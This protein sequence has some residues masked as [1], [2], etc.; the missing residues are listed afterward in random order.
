M[1]VSENGLIDGLELY[2]AALVA[3]EYA[4]NKATRQQVSRV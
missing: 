2:S 4:E 1:L 3:D